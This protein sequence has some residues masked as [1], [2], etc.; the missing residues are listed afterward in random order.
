M[1]EVEQ[2]AGKPSG[3][4]TLSHVLVTHGH[5]DHFGGLGYIRERTNAQIGIHELDIRNLNRYEERI[6]YV[7]HLLENFFIEAGV[8]KEDREIM[9]QTY[10]V[11]K[12]L[13][14][15]VPVDFT[16]DDVGMEVG[17]FEMLHAPGHCAGQV[18]IRLENVLFVGDVVLSKTSPHM[19][20]ELLTHHTGLAHYLDSLDKLDAWTNGIT[21]TLP[22]HERPIS[23]L[24]GRIHEIKTHHEERLEKICGLLGAPKTVAEISDLLFGGVKGYNS[25]LA[26]EEGRR[27][28]RVPLPARK[29]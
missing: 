19:A 22:G 13:F 24:S 11:N 28:Y 9:L 8:G 26:V 25:I 5:I 27:G 29:N 17:P 16:F 4:A 23:D 18:V 20:P 1:A 10:L 12:A 2:D 3:L 21:L 15:S 14:K 7:K 6:A